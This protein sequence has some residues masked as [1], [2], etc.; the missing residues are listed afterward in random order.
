MARRWGIILAAATVLLGSP[1]KGQDAALLLAADGK[2]P[3]ISVSWPTNLGKTRTVEGDRAWRS[4]A[5]QSPLGANIAAYAAVGG[6]RIEKGAGH[7]KGALVGITLSKLDTSK[8]FF[9]DIKVG[10][11][12][13]IRIDHIVMNQPAVLRPRTGLMQLK[14]RIDD[15]KACEL[16]GTNKNLVVTADP[17]DRLREVLVPGTFLLGGLDG[18]APEHGRIETGA[19]SDGSLTVTLTCP[20]TLLRHFKDPYQ[21]TTPGGFFE[22][23]S[24]HVEVEVLPK[25]VAEAEPEA[26]PAPAGSAPESRQPGRSPPP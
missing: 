11:S 26:P 16:D 18:S 10:A 22:P 12:V 5:D 13:T 9:E 24:I 25:A 14:Y 6:I 1:A 20:Y 21:R 8:L 15:L 17:R 19:A 7:P 2:Q 3:H 4:P 23:A